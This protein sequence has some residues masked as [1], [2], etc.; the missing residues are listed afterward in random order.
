MNVGGCRSK[1]QHRL[2]RQNISESWRLW[3]IIWTFSKTECRSAESKFEATI[4]HCYILAASPLVR[5]FI[6][7]THTHT[8]TQNAIMNLL[9]LT[10]LA[11]VEGFFAQRFFPEYHFR[12]AVLAALGVNVLLS[13]FYNVAIYPYFVNPLRHLPTVKV[14]SILFCITTGIFANRRPGRFDTLQNHL[15]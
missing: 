1:L 14:A 8:H 6:A 7:H 12:T 2:G 4:L 9:H 5:P 3:R 11:I 10:G 13:V 15:R